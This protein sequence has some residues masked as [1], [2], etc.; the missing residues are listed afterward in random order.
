MNSLFLNTVIYVV[1]INIVVSMSMARFATPSEVKPPGG[2][3]SALSFK[4]RIMHLFA[5][6]DQIIIA[7]SLIIGIMTYMA[8]ML[9]KKYPIISP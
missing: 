9:A 1:I 7:S 4:G 6:H 2:V 5:H 3:A 8:V